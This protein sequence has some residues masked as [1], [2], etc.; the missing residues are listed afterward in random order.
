[1]HN[2]LNP[3]EPPYTGPYVR[4]CER[5]DYPLRVILLLDFK[6][7]APPHPQEGI[8]QLL[9]MHEVLLF[10]LQGVFFNARYKVFSQKS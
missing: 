10:K 5:T 1:M 9:V 2:S 4:W 8:F 6:E 7:T 3:N